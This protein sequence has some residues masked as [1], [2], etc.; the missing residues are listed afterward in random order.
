MQ[1]I[2]L[3][4]MASAFILAGCLSSNINNQKLNSFKRKNYDNTLQNEIAAVHTSIT[5]VVP[6]NKIKDKLLVEFPITPETALSKSIPQSIS[7]QKL[8]LEAIKFQLK[9]G[10]TQKLTNIKNTTT[11]QTGQAPQ[12]TEERVELFQQPQVKSDSIP[13]PNPNPSFSP[14]YSTL[15][16]GQNPRM[17]YSAATA[18]YQEVKLLNEYV[19]YASQRENHTPY[20][21]RAQVSLTPKSRHAPYDAYTSISFFPDRFSDANCSQCT[22]KTVNSSA[23]YVIPLLVTENLESSNYSRA[24]DKLSQFGLGVM[25]A[26]NGIGGE[27]EL[28]S[29]TRKFMKTS[30]NDYNSLMTV[31]RTSDNTIRVRFGAMLTS[32]EKWSRKEYTLIPR[33]YNI[34]LLLL[35]PE[36][37]N[38]KLTA[39]SRT[40][41]VNIENGKELLWTP[42]E[43]ILLKTALAMKK[44]QIPLPENLSEE[45]TNQLLES[46]VELAAYVQAN[47]FECFDKHFDS[48][49]N[50]VGS[51]YEAT[52]NSTR[53][54][55]IASNCKK[56]KRV[57]EQLWT[58]IADLWVGG[59]YSYTAFQVPQINSLPDNYNFELPDSNFMFWAIDDGRYTRVNITG[60]Q[61]LDSADFTPKLKTYYGNKEVLLTPISFSPTGGGT[62]SRV[63]FQSLSSDAN[64]NPQKKIN[65]VIKKNRTTSSTYEL[66]YKEPALKPK[67]SVASSMK[68]IMIEKGSGVLQFF[69]KGANTSGSTSLIKIGN[70][71]ID[72]S[73]ASSSGLKGSS[74]YAGWFSIKKNGVINLRLS[75]LY[76]G[77][78]VTLSAAN[79]INGQLE[80]IQ[81]LKF[82]PIRLP[83][84]EKKK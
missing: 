84:P 59:Q 21:V 50:A 43:D 58:D 72:T 79:L 30:G 16:Q 65:L 26:I 48:F 11:S 3:A 5:S 8:L 49:C 20:L 53:S 52:D 56:A 2:L 1:K 25:A 51:T 12:T 14:D 34:T 4:F 9:L 23:P 74:T 83:K 18:L 24:N 13:I 45:T 7:E 82:M 29:M 28:S 67:F 17:Q 46:V 10:I 62:G 40:T 33:T 37:A 38:H 22:Q 81:N 19:N 69:I 6:W 15:T 80:P 75:D 76:P 70:G 36:E 77:T 66:M 78:E 71:R 57:K 32:S 68:N 61:K 54:N 35:V 63:L 31:G 60:G 44:Y 73:S 64:Y 47:R 55:D 39:V 27:A 41:F 42:H